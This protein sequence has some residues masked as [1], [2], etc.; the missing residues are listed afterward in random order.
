MVACSGHGETP[1]L[2]PSSKLKINGPVPLLFL[3]DI[4]YC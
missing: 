3:F 4:G 2:S 1:L